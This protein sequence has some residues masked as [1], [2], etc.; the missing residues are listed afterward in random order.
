MSDRGIPATYR[1]VKFQHRQSSRK[2]PVAADGAARRP[3]N[4][5]VL[6]LE[7]VH[8]AMPNDIP[9][10]QYYLSDPVYDDDV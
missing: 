7:T 1:Q 9:A 6:P 3:L 10:R 5:D 2:F 8:G 4:R